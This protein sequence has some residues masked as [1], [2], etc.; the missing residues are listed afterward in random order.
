MPTIQIK[1]MSCEH[2]A[3]SVRKRLLELDGI[4]DVQVDLQGNEATYSESKSVPLDIIKEAISE[5]GYEVVD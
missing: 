5:I 1:G 2:C 3:A 4:S